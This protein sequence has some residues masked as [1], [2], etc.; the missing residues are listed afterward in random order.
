MRSG[1]GRVGCMTDDR[2]LS[3]EEMIR[4][5]RGERADSSD[6][7]I[8]EARESVSD[9]PDIEGLDDIAVEIP[10]A[11]EFPEPLPQIQTTR[12]RRVRRQ[13]APMPQGPIST[14]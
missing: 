10:V 4:K 11:D 9:L 8:R 1:A 6:A 14:S 13:P 7:L 3:S 12:T 2:P 5:A